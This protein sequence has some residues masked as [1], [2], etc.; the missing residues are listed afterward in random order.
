MKA[1]I[2]RF[3]VST[4]SGEPNRALTEKLLVTSKTEAR[5]VKWSSW[6]CSSCSWALSASSV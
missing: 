5:M 4:N 1:W 3:S 6:D 2:L